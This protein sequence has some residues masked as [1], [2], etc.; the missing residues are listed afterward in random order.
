MNDE[1][2]K[3]FND[4]IE[5]RLHNSEWDI[6]IAHRVCI[7]IKMR[8][9]KLI[10]IAAIVP[11]IVTITALVLKSQQIN[12]AVWDDFIWQQV[13]GTY[14]SVFTEQAQGTHQNG[15]IFYEL[16]YIVDTALSQ[17]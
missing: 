5:K 8:R 2:K 4:E 6:M 17:R 1:Q 7:R 15:F 16:D 12:N 11:L 3:R 9:K 13:N 14:A 10:F